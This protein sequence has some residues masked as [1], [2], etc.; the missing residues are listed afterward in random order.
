MIGKEHAALDDKLAALRMA[1]RTFAAMLTI[2]LLN[3]L[4]LA[5][6]DH[7]LCT[8]DIDSIMCWLDALRG[9]S[10]TVR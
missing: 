4:G 7:R 1:S 8:S 2:A 5:H 3:W 9:R 10:L 6:M